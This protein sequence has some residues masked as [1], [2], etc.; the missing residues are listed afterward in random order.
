MLVPVK[1]GDRA[2]S[3]LPLDREVRRELAAAMAS[4]TVDAV[5][6]CPMVSRVSVLS[7]GSG[8]ASLGEAVHLLI[9]PEHLPPPG[10]QRADRLGGGAAARWS[11]SRS[12]WGTCP[13]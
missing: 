11:G 12:S 2:K 9:E 8:A 10:A 3:R 7:S 5:R 6:A 4:D 1:G 13:P